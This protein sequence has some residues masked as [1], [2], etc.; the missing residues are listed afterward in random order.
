MGY[1]CYIEVITYIPLANLLP[2][3]WDIQEGFASPVDA[4]IQY[5]LDLTQDAIVTPRMTKYITFLAT[6]AKYG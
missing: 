6:I 4:E 1:I 5:A 2:T 3:S